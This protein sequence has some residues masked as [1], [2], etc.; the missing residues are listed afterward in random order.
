MSTTI[1]VETR[2]GNK[3]QFQ[4]PID[5]LRQSV[6][7]SDMMECYSDDNVLIFFPTQYNKIANIYIEFI[8]DEEKGK[9]QIT[10]LFASK[11][12]IGYKKRSQLIMLFQLSHFLIHQQFFDVLLQN[13]LDTWSQNST[14]ISKLNDTIQ[15][16]IYLHCPFVFAPVPYQENL[17]FMKQ[18]TQ[19]ADNNDKDIV[20][21]KTSLYKSDVVLYDDN[22]I[23]SF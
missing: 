11:P 16:E 10:Q 15:R 7:F 2:N 17:T 23:K 9:Q 19:F 8:T 3:Q 5:K 18:W 1:I 20:I 12:I 6:L 21:D 13:L 22:S 4:V 14:I